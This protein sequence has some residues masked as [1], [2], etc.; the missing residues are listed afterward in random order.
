MRKKRPRT[1]QLQ[2]VIERFGEVGNSFK[3]R[4]NPMDSTL[5]HRG[6]ELFKAF[7]VSMESE[8][9]Y[10]DYCREMIWLHRDGIRFTAN[11]L[12]ITDL[13]RND[14]DWTEVHA[15]RFYPW[16]NV[17]SILNVKGDATIQEYTR[18]QI[19]EWISSLELPPVTYPLLY[20]EH[21]YLVLALEGAPRS[22]RSKGGKARL[23]QDVWGLQRTIE[24]QFGSPRSGPIELKIDVFSDEPMSLPDVDRFSSSIMDVLE[25]L[26]YKDDKQVVHLRP[27]VFESSAA[28]VKLE[29]R[30]DPMPHYEVQDIAPGSLFPL[31]E[32]FCSYYVVRVRG[33]A[34]AESVTHGA[35]N[36]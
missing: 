18:E 8:I 19:R 13:R 2:H 22:V 29:C 16:E 1:C 28:F 14:S 33:L 5:F 17:L 25:G 34:I 12:L 30:S 20:V 10:A 11:A 15:L 9:Q 6:S 7:G 24:A 32:G 4:E 27:R 3:G 36:P 31:A 26:A 23:K 35:G 21:G